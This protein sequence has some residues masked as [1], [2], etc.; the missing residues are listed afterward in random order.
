MRYAP[1]S[2][3]I[4]RLDPFAE[5]LEW[6][7]FQL[8][9]VL[10][11]IAEMYWFSA[12]NL[13]IP[14]PEDSVFAAH[15]EIK[16]LVFAAYSVLV[17]AGGLLAMTHGSLQSQYS[18]KEVI[19]RLC[20]GLLLVWAGPL[21]MLQI[22][23][24]NNS[25]VKVLMWSRPDLQH[26]AF[27][28]RTGPAGLTDAVWSVLMFQPAESATVLTIILIV[29]KIV[30]LLLLVV[31]WLMRAIAWS[32]CLA[33][34]PVALAS[35]GL[36]VTEGA[37]RMWWRMIGACVGSSLGQAACLYIWARLAFDDDGDAIGDT[38]QEL[39]LSLIYLVIAIVAM[40]KV[41]TAAFTWAR[42]K[43]TR[44]PGA[45]MIGGVVAWRT[46]DKLGLG[47]RA[48]RRPRSTP[49]AARNP[50]VRRHSTGGHS[51]A[52][53]AASPGTVN[54][55]SAPADTAKHAPRVPSSPRAPVPKPSQVPALTRPRRTAPA[56]PPTTRAPGSTAATRTTDPPG[57]A[58]SASPA[59]KAATPPP[60]TPTASASAPKLAAPPRRPRTTTPAPTGQ[61]GT[62]TPA[63][64]RT[65][66]PYRSRRDKEEP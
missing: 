6:A 25:V 38:S 49:D 1:N 66:A 46:M 62:A 31:S 8:F 55:T 59:K 41:H 61:S 52:R 40:W 20:L 47:R 54:P 22:R 17:V 56:A 26:P 13:T 57:T 51:P 29:L 27:N 5:F 32:A 60:T 39:S 16:A 36:A 48:H 7:Y 35:H 15:D 65:V 30:A 43:S 24:V 9:D 33:F 12:I 42:G 50:N 37:A 28:P 14:Y 44:V 45:R 58:A 53:A 21:I 23:W 11:R 64:L 4:T 63:R 18:P 2:L 3:T 19:P 34:A 10:E